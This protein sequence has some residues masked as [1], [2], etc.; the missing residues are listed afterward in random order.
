MWPVFGSI[1]RLLEQVFYCV[2]IHMNSRQA[3]S[4]VFFARNYF[5]QVIFK[6]IFSSFFRT[7]KRLGT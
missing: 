3:S 6:V 5:F 2:T 7:S 1:F 4:E